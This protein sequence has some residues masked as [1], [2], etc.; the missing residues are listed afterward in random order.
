MI[1]KEQYKTLSQFERHFK[2]AK[3][4]YVRGVYSGDVIT[5]TPIYHSLGHHLANP[6]CSECILSM[7]KILGDEYEKYIK[8]YGRK[9]QERE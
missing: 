5:V 9:E 7:F 4:G 1:S 3:L 2:T 6:N 8:R